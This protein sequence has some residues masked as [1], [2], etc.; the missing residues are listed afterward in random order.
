MRVG[1]RLRLSTKFT[2]MAILSALCCAAV[3]VV[4]AL[5]AADQAAM[6]QEK[7]QLDNDL[8]LAWH[9]LRERGQQVSLQ[10]GRLLAGVT[11]LDGDTSIVDD[12][13]MI[14]GGAAT[15]FN[16]TT[17]VATTIRRG[18]GTR[19][20][21]TKLAAGPAYDAVVTRHERY[22]GVAAILGQPY[23]AL[24]DPILDGAGTQIGI[25]FVGRPLSG[26]QAALWATGR[27]I[28]IGSG[29]AMLVIG[30]VFSL[31]AGWQFRPLHGLIAAM[32]RLADHDL[33]VEI[34]GAGRGDE[35]GAMAGAVQVFK[36]SMIR[37]ADLSAQQVA[38]DAA[39]AAAQKQAMNRTADGFQMKVGELAAALSQAAGTLEVAAKGMSATALETKQKAGQVTLAAADASS[40]V[41]T[42]AAAAEQLA[43][44]IAEISRQVATAE[45]LTGQAAA[46]AA[47]T[48][49]IVGALAQGAEQIGLVVGLIGSIARQTNLLALNA[50]IEAARAGDAGKGFAV[51]ASEV[52]NLASQTAQA[53]G[54]IGAQ[55]DQIQ[56]ST[57]SAVAA[58][59]RIGERVEA[60]S[61]LSAAIA[62]AVEQQ[63]TATAEIAR[64]VLQTSA[65]TQ[66]VTTNIA[67]VTRA[68]TETGEA[69]RQV[70]NSAGMLSRQAAGLTGEV[71]ALVRDI[72]AA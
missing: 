39:A 50:T 5:R 67:S 43:S 24:Y 40:S 20:T 65:R 55:I 42:V 62:T 63:G 33:A 35:I 6:A 12:V 22:S 30:V 69:A 41:A 58:I 11:V 10:D 36:D 49:G 59:A 15:V 27:R 38:R 68:A 19:A 32:R 60:I 9:L 4:L 61:G 28:V 56:A 25:L 45:Q 44:S 46:D 72:R 16:G 34:P 64:N 8:R 17:R 54:D 23:V 13:H 37:A 7:E 2:L 51:V 52:K 66:D 26:L 18:D 53:T 14:A 21:G 70:L 3:I 47:D 31:M 57:R 71:Q 1:S 29:M 48:N